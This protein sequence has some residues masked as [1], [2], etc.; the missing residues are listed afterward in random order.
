M[1]VW[2]LESL[3]LPGQYLLLITGSPRLWAAAQQQQLLLSLQSKFNLSLLWKF[4]FKFT[5]TL[6]LVISSFN[7]LSEIWI[8][9]LKKEE[10]INLKPRCSVAARASHMILD[11]SWT[12]CKLGLETVGVSSR[13][14]CILSGSAVRLPCLMLTTGRSPLLTAQAGAAGPCEGHHNNL[15]CSMS[16]W[17]VFSLLFNCNNICY[18]VSTCFRNFFFE[19]HQNRGLVQV[20]KITVDR[21]WMIDRW[22]IIHHLSTVQV[23]HLSTLLEIR[24]FQ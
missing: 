4:K 10:I 18:E 16:G 11:R 21:W 6:I 12:G 2:P 13:C 23:H 7:M 3:S 15:K 9:S 5:G 24:D 17:K 1:S 19:V 8:W 20:L 22:W 14:C